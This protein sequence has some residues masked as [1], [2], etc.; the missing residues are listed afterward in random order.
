MHYIERSQ[1][2]V[3]DEK[4]SQA[5]DFR[6]TVIEVNEPRPYIIEGN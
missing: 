1:R 3:I 4:L 5:V 6:P 2:G